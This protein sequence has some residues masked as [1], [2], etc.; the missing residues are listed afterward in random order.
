MQG[1]V[2]GRAA[3]AAR[4]STPGAQ[5]GTLTTSASSP[6]PTVTSAPVS[7]SRRTIA[8]AIGPWAG[9]TTAVPTE[10]TSRSPSR[11]GSPSAAGAPSRSPTQPAVR[12]ALVVQARDRLLADVAALGEAH[13]ALV[14]PGLLRGSSRSSS[15]GRSAGG[16][17]RRA[18][19]R[20]P[21][22]RPPRRPRPAPPRGPGRS[23]RRPPAGPLRR[24]W[25]PRGSAG[26]RSRPRGGRARGRAVP[27]RS[28]RAPRARPARGP[29]GARRASVTSTSRPTLVHRQVAKQGVAGRVGSVSSRNPSS[30]RSTRMSRLHL[31]LAVEQ[32]GVAAPTPPR[33][34]RRRW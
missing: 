30:A 31:A 10:P 2:Q 29:L 11:I 15:H 34:P 18:G 8:S 23:R 3:R 6:S 25:P 7:A 13:R 14:D 20:A 12:P 21:P 16:R 26:R 5:N 28:P 1:L 32:R 19:S 4:P 22:R 17:A 33:A 27:R 24:R 9:E